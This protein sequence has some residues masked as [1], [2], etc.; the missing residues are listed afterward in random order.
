MLDPQMLLQ[1]TQLRGLLNDAISDAEGHLHAFDEGSA[2]PRPDIHDERRAF[3]L[4]ASKLSEIARDQTP[5]ELASAG[6]DLIGR[7]R[8]ELELRPMMDAQ[9][10]M[11]REARGFVRALAQVGRAL[12]KLANLQSGTIQTSLRVARDK[13]YTD[14]PSIRDLRDSIEHA[15]DRRRGL[16]K[17]GKPLNLPRH[18][19][20]V[21]SGYLISGT[22]VSGR[23]YEEALREHTYGATS[24]DGN[25]VE[26]EI[27][28]S[29]L[30]AACDAVRAAIAAM[31][32]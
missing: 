17:K 1:M 18:T 29:T 4:V 22:L 3:E 8:R 9:K 26:V 32:S 23:L 7:A 10:S 12:D 31:P 2:E 28:A 21:R 20:D 24:D 6:P 15:E 16:D 19:G 13:F 11:V 14:L 30:A 27:S 25:Y 5:N